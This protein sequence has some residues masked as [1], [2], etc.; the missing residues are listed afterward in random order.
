MSKKLAAL[1]KQEI[2]LKAKIKSAQADARK[3]EADAKKAVEKGR[4]EKFF[5]LASE[6]GLFA[7]SDEVLAA[8]FAKIKADSKE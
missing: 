6:A 4:R 7:L 3:A 2:E 1:L 5:A 8:G